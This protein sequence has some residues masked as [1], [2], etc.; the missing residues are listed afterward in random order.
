MNIQSSVSAA[1]L[2]TFRWPVVNSGQSWSC[3][4]V[5]M[6]DIFSIQWDMQLDSWFYAGHAIDSEGKVYTVNV[7]F[8]RGEALPDTP[9]ADQGVTLGV[10]IGVGGT[11]QHPGQYHMAAIPQG[12]GLSDD[13]DHPAMMTIP[14]AT[15]FSYSIAYQTPPASIVY[16]G[17]GPDDPAV[18]TK[19]ATYTLSLS[20]AVDGAGSAMAIELQLTDALGTCMEGYSGFVGGASQSDDG[21][22]TYEIPQ[23]QLTITGGSLTVGGKT[24]TIVAG[25]L[26]HDRQTYTYPPGRAPAPGG[27]LYR[28]CWIPLQF[29]NGVSAAL[30]AGWSDR[31]KG[32]QWISGREA[33]FP[34]NGG[35][36]NLFF[37]EGW[38]RYNGGALVQTAID[39]WDYDINIFDPN[40]VDES[41]HWTS[42]VTGRT[43]C[44]RWKIS[45]SE[46]LGKWGL[47]REI[48]LAA[49][50]DGCEF[51]AKD[52]SPFSEGAVLMF[53][54]AA[55][56]LRIG[57]GFVEQMGYN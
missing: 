30:S 57:Y 6:P 22:F 18:G 52:E 37:P 10:G 33:G 19:G 42:P 43:Y 7:Y 24:V 21:L 53:A 12:M 15:D 26:W 50:V 3:P 25:N 47:P 40:D 13:P 28:G 34:P 17:V 56:S 27:P 39:D 14:P 48:Y 44:T 29:D 55:C 9:G 1:A 5:S 11:G 46:R 23:P 35:T 4:R 51:V 45:F 16:V 36:G 31:P 32:S 49:V 20:D 41:P 38:D 8:G 54:D 2:S